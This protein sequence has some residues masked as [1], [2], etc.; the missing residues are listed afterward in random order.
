MQK[1]KLGNS[2]IEVSLVGL[3]ANNF[4]GRT[5]FEAS[6]HVVDKALD[7]GVTLF[8]TSDNYGNRGGS[9]EFLGRILG[10]RRKDIVLATKFGLPMDDA[11]KLRGASRRY[12]MQAVEASLRR[13]KTDWIDLYQVHFPDPRTPIEET[14]RA[15]DDLR[16]SGK[17]RSVGCSNFSAAQLEEA[18]GVS[19]R[20]QL[21]SFVT[22]QDEY[23]VLERDLE[24]DRLPIMRRHG[25]GLLPYFPL[26]SGLLTGK[27]R[28]DAPLP[29]GT[30]LAGNVPR[31]KDVFLNARNWRMVGLL[32]AFAA[33]R[34]HTLL[35]LAMSWLASRPYI[36]SIIAGATRPE[37]VEQNIAAIGWH[38]SDADLAEIDRITL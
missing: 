34:G 3:G 14:L 28:Q 29:S 5:D 6:R 16:Q 18:I 12:A 15:L 7:L 20:S 22:C 1:R 31:G 30:R 13:L 25:I 32:R 4:G 33:A 21:P 26:A 10:A 38:L 2:G 23:N 9:E 8:D 19:Q 11:G 35:E 17:V 36:P 24:K 37:Q 27:Y